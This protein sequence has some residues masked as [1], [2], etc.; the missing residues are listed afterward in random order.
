[1]YACYSLNSSISAFVILHERWNW[2]KIWSIWF[3]MVS[4]QPGNHSCHVRDFGNSHTTMQVFLNTPIRCFLL[5][6]LLQPMGLFV[7]LPCVSTAALNVAFHKGYCYSV[8]A[9]LYF[10]LGPTALNVKVI[11]VNVYYLTQLRW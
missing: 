3:Y 2:F 10:I 1:M 5:V 6:L 8:W 11:C 9:Y 4:S 7:Y